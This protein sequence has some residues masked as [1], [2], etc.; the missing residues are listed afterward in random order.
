MLKKVFLLLSLLILIGS[1]KNKTKQANTLS[2][3]EFATHFHIQTFSDFYLLQI[4]EPWPGADTRYYVLAKNLSEIPDSLKNYPS[5]KIPVKNLVVT[6]TTHLAPLEM[7]DQA[8]RLVA[9]PNTRYVSSETF[10]KRIKAGKIKDIGNGSGLNI[11]QTLA[12]NPGL[13]M[14]FSGG[15]DQNKYEYFERHKI[16]VLYNADW[17]ENHPLGKAEW[18]KVFGILFEKNMRAHQIFNEIKTN[19]LSIKSKVKAKNQKPLVFQG[20][21][22][23]DKWYVPGGKSYAAQFITDAGGKYAW[24]DN[25]KQ[26]S[27]IMNFENVLIKLN[28]ADIW[29]NPGTMIS[30]T[31]ILKSIPQAKSFPSYV[32]DKIYTYSL[33]KGKNGG[34]IYFE[35]AG[36]H[37]DWVLADLYHIFYPEE[38]PD[39]HFH[40]YSVLLP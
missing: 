5:I 28:E 12:L 1:C 39:Y 20:G 10:R 34:L 36:M 13:I 17:M 4:T 9:F 2:K 15:T 7:L 8:D 16:P 3:E 25:D 24:E 33:T 6:S 32:N 22:F 31:S 30:K 19:Y 23:G 29:L 21:N 26:A 38:T 14:A 40:Y 37:P 11:E 35:T 27:L 18:I